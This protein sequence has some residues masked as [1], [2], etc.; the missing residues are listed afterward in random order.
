[1]KI[2]NCQQ[3]TTEWLLSRAGVVT[4]SE[5]DALV[6]PKWEVRKGQ[7]VR[8]YLHE[9][10]GGRVMGYEGDGGGTWAMGQGQVKE[11]MGLA[12]YEFAFGVSI[13]RVGL[14]L[15]DD[16]KTGCS[17]DG[18]IG[19]SSGIE[20]KCPTVPTHL[21]YLLG[22][23]VPDKYL[24]QVHFCMYVTGRPHWVFVS[25]NPHLPPLV[26]NVVRSPEAIAAIETALK[27][28]LPSLDAA[29]ARVR[30]MMKHA[31]GGRE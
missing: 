17:P 9:K 25:Y 18:L 6:S 11:P 3:N 30:A 29:E 15:S 1:M 19:D 31:Q 13:Q 26:V 27:D 28:F 22:Q 21:E 24:A 10:L 7:G 23:R 5:A 2:L 14:C 8:T 16:G 20:L 4:A 12:W